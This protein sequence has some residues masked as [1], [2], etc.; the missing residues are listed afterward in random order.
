MT[1]SKLLLIATITTIAL[2]AL[3][4]PGFASAA[5]TSI[6][7]TGELQGLTIDGNVDVPAGK[8]CRIALTEVKGDVTVEGTLGTA[9]STYDRN[10][11]VAGGKIFFGRCAPLMQPVCASHPG[12]TIAGSLTIRS[13][14][15]DNVVQLVTVGKDL[16]AGGNSGSLTLFDLLVGRN[17]VVSDNTGQATIV[18]RAGNSLS[19]S[20]NTLAP[21]VSQS[22]AQ[23]FLGQCAA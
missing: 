7:C 20:G 23:Q 4:L 18:A 19:C 6:T 17:L 5:P 13:S 15:N 16:I 2:T 9:G 14:S 3:G 21:T 11:K 22:T 10:L 8:T 12:T 1:R